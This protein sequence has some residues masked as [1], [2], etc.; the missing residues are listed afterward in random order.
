L[1][2]GDAIGRLRDA[3]GRLGQKSKATPTPCPPGT[4]GRLSVA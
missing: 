3:S 2:L 1:R 4:L